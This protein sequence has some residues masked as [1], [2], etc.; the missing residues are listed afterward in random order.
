MPRTPTLGEPAWPSEAEHSG[1][2]QLRSHNRRVRACARAG[3]VFGSKGVRRHRRRRGRRTPAGDDM[4]AEYRMR[5]MRDTPGPKQL[6]SLP[7]FAGILCSETLPRNNSANAVR[8]FLLWNS[9]PSINNRKGRQCSGSDS[10]CG[11]SI[12]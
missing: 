1:G 3:E 9:A 4:L 12:P 11:R 2:C 7:F 8:S 10:G 6:T 5:R